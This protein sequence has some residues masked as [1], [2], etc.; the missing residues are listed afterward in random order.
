MVSRQNRLHLSPP[1][2]LPP[3][4]GKGS[5][6]A[7]WQEQ[8]SSLLRE[9]PHRGPKAPEW[10]LAAR[11][12]ACPGHRQPGSLWPWAAPLRRRTRFSHLS[13]RATS[14]QNKR[15]LMHL[16]VSRRTVPS[17]QSRSASKTKV[18]KATQATLVQQHLVGLMRLCATQL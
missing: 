12:R 11:P 3:S 1:M 9:S 4:K 13:R 16:L 7:Q 18:P 8:E 10:H 14:M 2:S 17:A 5:C 15:V 6:A